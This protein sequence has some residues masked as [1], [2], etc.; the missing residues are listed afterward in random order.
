[1]KSTR[2]EMDIVNAYAELGSYRA[3][4]ALCRTTHKT[5]KRV[6]ER[7]RAAT[8]S[9]GGRRWPRPRNTEGV[10][11]LLMARVQATAGRITAKRL[12]AVAPAPAA[13]WHR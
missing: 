8:D 9:E 5:V 1:M 13:A 6:V 7:R 11:T 2:D 12:V 4:A 10:Q 3:T